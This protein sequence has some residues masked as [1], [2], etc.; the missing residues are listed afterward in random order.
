M[1]NLKVPQSCFHKWLIIIK[2]FLVSKLRN[3]FTN[4]IDFYKIYYECWVKD[5]S[6]DEINKLT[7]EFFNSDKLK[8]ILESKEFFWELSENEQNWSDSEKW[9]W[10]YNSIQQ[11]LSTEKEDI[12][13]YFRMNYSEEELLWQSEWPDEFP[14]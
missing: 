9:V 7:L 5:K 10:M 1:K 3:Y 14:D 6:E 4:S 11:M 12:R 13:K 8:F 2:F